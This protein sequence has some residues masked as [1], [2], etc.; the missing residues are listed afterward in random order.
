MSRETLSEVARQNTMD[1][2]TKMGEDQKQELR[3]ILSDGLKDGKTT[4][5][6]ARDMEEKIDEMS[7]TRAQAI[8]RTETTRAAN[9]GNWYKYKE[10]NFGSFTV[11]FTSEACDLC[12]EL[13]DN[14]VFP[15]ETVEMLPQSQPIR[16]ACVLPY[17]TLKQQK[18]TLISM[19]M[20]FMMAAVEMKSSNQKRI[21]R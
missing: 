5:E 10:K 9:I 11:D 21:N 2:V 20:M 7:R 6:I 3:D 19:D 16:I 14:I 17:S 15:I 12:V 1:L 8:T 18:N 4:Y 13:Y